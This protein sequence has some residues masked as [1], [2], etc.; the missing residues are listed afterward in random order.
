MTD[1]SHLEA[2]QGRLARETKR[3]ANA[4]NANE[5]AF[6]EREIA[7]CRKEI[8]GEYKF[9]GIKPLTLEEIMM[10]DDELLAELSGEQDDIQSKYGP[11]D[12]IPGSA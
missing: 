12:E 6:R 11:H 2:L 1:L 7:A 8:A 10:S 5:Q 4:S 9:L 3:L